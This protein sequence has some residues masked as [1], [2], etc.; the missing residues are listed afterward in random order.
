M[1]IAKQDVKKLYSQNNKNKKDGLI[2]KKFN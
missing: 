1:F 2:V